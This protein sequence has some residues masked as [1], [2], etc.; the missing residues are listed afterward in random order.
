M[1]TWQRAVLILLGLFMIVC[2]FYFMSNPVRVVWL[3]TIILSIYWIAS[4]IV[5][6]IL[7]FAGSEML[8]GWVMADGILSILLGILLVSDQFSGMATI[9]FVF[10]FWVLFSGIMQIIGSLDMKKLGSSNWGLLCFIG[11]VAAIIGFA[12]LFDPVLSV[13]G[14]TAILVTLFI[15][16]GITAIVLAFHKS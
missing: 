2:G 6:V 14:I 12:T 7:Y 11:V 15:V 16:E 9:L 4:G 3:L 5:K 1:K 13:I 8:S 10:S